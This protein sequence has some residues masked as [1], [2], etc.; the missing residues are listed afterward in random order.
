MFTFYIGNKIFKGRKKKYWNCLCE[1]V[2][3]GGVTVHRKNLRILGFLMVTIWYYGLKSSKRG[4]LLQGN[5][6]LSGI[7]TYSNFE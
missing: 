5:I 6:K 7:M 3:T 4:V 2:K 1:S